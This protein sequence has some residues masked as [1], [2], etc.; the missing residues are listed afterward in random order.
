M[1]FPS[2]WCVQFQRR[3][4]KYIC[5]LQVDGT[6]CSLWGNCSTPDSGDNENAVGDIH[7]DQELYFVLVITVC[8]L[9]VMVAAALSLYRCVWF[10]F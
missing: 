9:T 3:M 10:E 7:F 2:K 1:C 5:E 4:K 6:D 8:G